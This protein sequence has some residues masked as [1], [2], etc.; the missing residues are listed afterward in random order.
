MIM[1]IFMAIALS[2]G[3]LNFIV[4]LIL[5]GFP[6]VRNNKAFTYRNFMTLYY[7]LASS[8]A[9]MGASVLVW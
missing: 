2:F 5:F 1:L 9:G 3:A 8:I 4:L 7:I 6:F